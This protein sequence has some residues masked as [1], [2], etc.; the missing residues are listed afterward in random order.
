[1]ATANVKVYS[2]NL[3]W[4]N[5]YQRRGGNG[6]SA[7]RLLAQTSG[8]QEY[9]I[10]GLQECGDVKRYLNDA[11]RE[12]LR[13]QYGSIDGGWG[14]AIAYRESRWSAISSGAEIVSEDTR[15]QYFGTRAVQWARLRRNDGKIVL[16]LNHHGPLPI[17]SGGR[18]G[19]TN[20]GYNIMK[21]IANNLHAGDAVIM[22]GDFNSK[23]SSSLF[24]VLDKH[25]YRTITSGGWGIDHILS[26]CGDDSVIDARELGKGG[27][28]HPAMNAVFRL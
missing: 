6:R 27:S 11:S 7:G 9:D 28:D 5:L 16:F 4:W 3:F 17:N 13:E 14:L 24:A 25:M 20:T 10:L 19:G 12:G 22:V 21:T 2:H 18:C 8:P 1:M 15:Q 23:S 26:S